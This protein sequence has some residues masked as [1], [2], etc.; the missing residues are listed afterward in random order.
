M[1]LSPSVAGTWV[2]SCFSDPGQTGV[3]RTRHGV[4]NL[5]IRFIA[6]TL[7]E[8]V[9]TAAETSSVRMRSLS[10]PGEVTSPP[11]GSAACGATRQARVESRL[12]ASNGLRR[13][14]ALPIHAGFFANRQRRQGLQLWSSLDFIV[15]QPLN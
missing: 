6:Y 14:T 11:I 4:H 7:D 13:R 10:R 1:N 15:E 5:L 8:D 2:F 3:L 9:L 12:A